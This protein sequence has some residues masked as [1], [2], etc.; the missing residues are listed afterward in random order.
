MSIL[1]F[2]PNHTPLKYKCLIKVYI[3]SLSVKLILTSQEGLEWAWPSMIQNKLL[4][5]QIQ[6]YLWA[7]TTKGKLI[8]YRMQNNQ[9]KM[10]GDQHLMRSP[11]QIKDKSTELHEFELLFMW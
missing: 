8:I 11:I 3:G 10:T 1:G 5:I 7:Y 6:H 9:Q 4:I 2:T